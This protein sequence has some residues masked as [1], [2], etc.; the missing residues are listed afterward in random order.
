MWYAYCYIA[1]LFYKH[2]VGS[3][4]ASVKV[5]D[6]RRQQFLF[7]PVLVT[8]ST[9]SMLLHNLFHPPPP[10]IAFRAAKSWWSQKVNGMRDN[11]KGVYPVFLFLQWYSLIWSTGISLSFL[12]DVPTL[13]SEYEYQ[14]LI[15][16]QRTLFI[17]HH[18]QSKAVH[19][20]LLLQNLILLHHA[21]I[22]QSSKVISTRDTGKL[23][24]K[25]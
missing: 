13:W 21:Y 22:F 5:M 25:F 7:W 1:R 16:Y 17:Y 19:S 6:V 12:Y 15:F 4:L 10:P 23:P 9:V 24:G 8:I 3:I 11:S 18:L 14:R 20:I 2:G